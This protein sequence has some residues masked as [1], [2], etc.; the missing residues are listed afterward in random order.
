[1]LSGYATGT[2]LKLTM[3]DALGRTVWSQ[4]QEVTG[5][6]MEVELPMGTLSAGVYQ[7][8][9][10]NRQMAPQRIIKVE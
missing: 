6:R 1:M 9:D 7:L 8:V 10:E 5:K 4:A 2:I 3:V